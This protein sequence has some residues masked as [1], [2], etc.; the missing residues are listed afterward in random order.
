MYDDAEKGTLQ[1]FQVRVQNNEEKDA[2]LR[3][4]VVNLRTA[5]YLSE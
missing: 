2:V 4:I 3:Y 1:T 5:G